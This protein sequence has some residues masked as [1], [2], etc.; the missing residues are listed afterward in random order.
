MQ[1]YVSA[2]TYAMRS[3][4]NSRFGFAWS[5]RNLA[6]MPAADFAA[7]TDALLVRLAAAIADSAD[8]PEAACGSA[9]CTGASPAPRSRRAGARS[10]PGSRPLLA[11]TTPAADALAG[12]PSAPIT[13]ELRT[14]TGTPYST[15][16]PLP[17]ELSS[18]SP[19]GELSHEPGG[20]WTPTLTAS[21]ASG[22]STTSFYFR[23]GVSG[24]SEITAAAAGKVG[25]TQAVTVAE[26][27]SNPVPPPPPPPSAGGE[28]SSG[29]GGADPAPAAG[30]ATPTSDPPTVVTVVAAAATRHQPRR[31]RCSS[32]AG[33]VRS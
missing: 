14:S 20:P 15:G 10:P 11:F 1:D 30:S 7:Q 31:P 12:R 21:I 3:A 8:A 2:Q 33:R 4:G 19:T 32:S 17:V 5:P 26:I 25:A 23:D 13:V 28:G 27:P 22:Q 16:L 29:G 9:W 18:S 6:G 24:P